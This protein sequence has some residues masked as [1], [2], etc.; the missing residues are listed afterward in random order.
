MCESHDC[1][2][3]EF[4]CP[5]GPDGC[6]LESYYICDGYSD[7]MDHTDEENCESTTT[8]NVFL[9]HFGGGVLGDVGWALWT[10]PNKIHI[11]RKKLKTKW[12]IPGR[13]SLMIILT[14]DDCRRQCRCRIRKHFNEKV[15]YSLILH[16]LH[17]T[18][19]NKQVTTCIVLAGTLSYLLI[20]PCS[21]LK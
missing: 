8:G 7:C 20:Y 19:A 9:T 16:Q 15:S 18:K 12:D 2:E 13:W 1:L 17:R 3:S 4:S 6:C 21:G 10:W 11:S 14:N 5:V